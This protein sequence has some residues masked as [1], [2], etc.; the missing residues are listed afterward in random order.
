MHPAI[1]LI[2]TALAEAATGLVLLVWP[3]V[4]LA[5]LLGVDPVSPE[6]TSCARIAGAALL[7]NGVA[8]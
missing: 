1:L 6:T 7:A 8:C 2:V 5:L 4:L 3:P